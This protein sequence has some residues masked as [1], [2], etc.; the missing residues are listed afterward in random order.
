MQIEDEA[1]TEEGLTLHQGG[2]S[3]VIAC[4]ALARE[5]LALKDIND[6]DHMDLTCLP[7]IYHGVRC[8]QTQIRLLAHL[9]RLC[10]LRHRRIA[11]RK[12][13]RAW[14]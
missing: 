10:G 11:G 12:M 5:I 1:L 14:R 4:G 7:A 2:R 9:H 8:S 3:L 13:P 6:W